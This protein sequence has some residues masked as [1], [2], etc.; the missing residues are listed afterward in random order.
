MTHEFWFKPKTYGYGATPVTWE[1]WA[2]V[3]AYVLL[4]SAAMVVLSLHQTSLSAWLLL[5]AAIAASTAAL[6]VV[7]VKKTDGG[8][9][10]SWGAPQNSGKNS[11]KHD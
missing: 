2:L 10:W 3:A 8:W 6:V 1:G 4:I 11:R 7:S 5:M 9:R